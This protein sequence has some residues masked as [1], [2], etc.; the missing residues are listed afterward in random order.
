VFAD[1]SVGF[2]TVRGPLYRTR[3]GGAHWTKIET[4][5]VFWPMG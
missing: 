5:G 1:A 4:P 3:D 2:G